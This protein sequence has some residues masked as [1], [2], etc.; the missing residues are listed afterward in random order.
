MLPKKYVELLTSYISNRI[1]RIKLEDTYSDL[2]E[3]EA[4]L[5]KGSVFGA[6]VY[7]LYTSDISSMCNLCKSRAQCASELSNHRT[8]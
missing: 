6:I 7:L 8:N 2:K 3:K 1:F 4:S 5:P